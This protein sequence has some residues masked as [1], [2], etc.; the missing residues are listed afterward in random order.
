MP[1]TSSD[2]EYAQVVHVEESRLDAS[3]AIQFKED[4]RN[5]T[6]GADDIILEMSN[7][8]FL[9]SSGLGSIVAVFKGL[10]PDRAMALV[11]LQPAV[12]KVMRL[13]RMNTVFAIFPTLEDA[14]T[15][16][17]APHAAE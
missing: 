14:L 17:A 9:D 6:A 11:G 7:V 1:L 8:E 16:A 4:F 15:A 13:T 10:G 3:I 5:L 2:H 12:E